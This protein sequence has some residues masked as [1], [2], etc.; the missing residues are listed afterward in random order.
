MTRFF[1][2][3]FVAI[4]VACNA[5][6][7]TPQ[8]LRML[9]NRGG[10]Y[11]RA[12]S[13]IAGSSRKSA[14]YFDEKTGRFVIPK[15]PNPKNIELPSG[16]MAALPMA[17]TD[18]EVLATRYGPDFKMLKQMSADQA[19][20]YAEYIIQDRIFLSTSEFYVTTTVSGMKYCQMQ[21]N[22]VNNT[23]R[24]LNKIYVTYSWGNTKTSV[25]FSGI[26]AL[27]ASKHE[28]AL[29]GSVCDLVTGGAQYDVDT[30]SMEGL[31]EEQCRI[32]VAKL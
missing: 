26:D 10:S 13:V 32:R 1:I 17:K 9:E 3:A 12:S 11:E 5:S 25:T 14:V 20:E 15:N 19:K 4:L 6:A 22:I 7:Q 27:G 18:Q 23:P 21:L 16:A 29:A 30:C 28:I 31:T 24:R 2:C 8:Q